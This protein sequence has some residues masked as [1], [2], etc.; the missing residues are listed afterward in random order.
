MSNG[1]SAMAASLLGDM[2]EEIG[3]RKVL[4]ILADMLVTTAK[5]AQVKG[6]EP[7]WSRAMNASVSLKSLSGNL[8][9]S[10]GLAAEKIN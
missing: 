5:R 7:E 10:C 3:Y 9:E 1:G 2:V 8:S 6:N 4:E